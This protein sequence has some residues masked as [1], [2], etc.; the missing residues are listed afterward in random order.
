MLAE[1]VPRRVG[2][3]GRHRHRQHLGKTAIGS[4]S[5]ITTVLSSLAV[6][7]LTVRRGAGVEL[8]GRRR[9]GRAERS[10]M[11][12]VAGIQARVKLLTTLAA[13]NGLP[14]WN[15]T[16]RRSGT[17]T[18]AR[19]PITPTAPASRAPAGLI[20][21]NRV[22]PSKMSATSPPGSECR[23]RG[24][25]RA[26]AGRMSSVSR[27]GSVAGVRA[28]AAAACQ[29]GGAKRRQERKSGW[30]RFLL[31]SEGAGR[32]L[33]PLTLDASILELYP[34]RRRPRRD[35]L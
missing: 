19:R 14:S 4:V 21:E 32:E 28:S 12:C 6:S 16:W 2:D 31:T 20:G 17:C 22:R 18:S 34:V 25:G 8:G 23:W 30:D 27:P 11:P 1:I 7:P 33:M 24:P 9:W 15:V 5:V 13:V 10:G 3:D 35:A 26:T 29:C